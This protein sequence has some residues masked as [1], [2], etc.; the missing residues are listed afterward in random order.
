MSEGSEID[1]R[2]VGFDLV[3]SCMEHLSTKKAE[4]LMY[5]FLAGP[6]GIPADTIAGMEL[7]ELADTAT[8]WFADYV[9]PKAVNAFFG[10]LS[11]LMT[12]KPGT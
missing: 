5:E 2:D 10:A 11:R 7:T 4:G 3:L 1:A 12:D 9:D 6:F 8:K